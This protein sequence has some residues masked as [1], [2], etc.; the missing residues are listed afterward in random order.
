MFIQRSLASKLEKLKK[1]FPAIALLGPRQSGKTTLA[2][3]AFPDHQYVNLEALD[4]RQ[5]ALDDPQG[6]LDQYN[7]GSGVIL[8]EIQNVPNLLSY[9]QV[10]I[11][12]KPKDGFY[13]LTGS[14][15]ILLNQ[16]IAQTLAGRI[17]IQ[18]LLPFSIEELSLSLHLPE[19]LFTLLFQGFYPTLYAKRVHAEDWY[20]AYI[21]TYVERDVRLIRNVSDLNLFQKFLKLC[22]GRIGQLLNLTSLSDDCGISV[23]TARAWISILEA[24]Y[25]IF[26]LPPH[27]E[28]FS[29]RLIKSPKLYFYDSGLAC[30]LLG[31]DSAE[32]LVQHYLRGGIFESM[33]VIDLLKQRF[34]A[35]KNAN[36]YFWRDKSGLEVDCLLDRAQ[37]L[38]PIEIKSAQTIHSDFFTSLSRFCEIANISPALAYVVYGGIEDQKRQTGHALSWKRL[39]EIKN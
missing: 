28:N 32:S 17:S 18:T 12:R 4:S 21:Q 10:R 9:L 22:V 34:N 35:G 8:D 11:D 14:H 27:H 30:H 7:K 1:Q 16:H 26:L 20:K 31:I 6:F 2:R 36:L 19:D 38:V 5:F 33:V 3:H 29:K 23:N 25:I 39:S 15:N 24:S 37:E 13:I